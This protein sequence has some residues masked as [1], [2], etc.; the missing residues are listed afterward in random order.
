V[1]QAAAAS[2]AGPGATGSAELRVVVSEQPGVVRLR[3]LL[4]DDVPPGS[5][6][7]QLAGR[8]VIVLGQG[9]DGRRRRSRR[10]QLCQP[11]VEDSARAEYEPDGSLTIT[12]RARPE[13]GPSPGGHP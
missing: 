12:L 7:V 9:I 6:E 4:P 8:S 1:A 2:A 5:V 3:V 10:L 13:D 11:V